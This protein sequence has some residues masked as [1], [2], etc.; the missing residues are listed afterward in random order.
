MKYKTFPK[1]SQTE[2]IRL[3]V[4]LLDQD[5]LSNPNRVWV[6]V[7][8][9]RKEEGIEE[10]WVSFAYVYTCK[11]ISIDHST[12]R[13]LLWNTTWWKFSVGVPLGVLTPA[14]CIFSCIRDTCP[15]A[16][17]VF[18][19]YAKRT[20]PRCRE[21]F[22]RQYKLQRSNISSFILLL[23]QT[24]LSNFSDISSYNVR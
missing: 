6:L 11:Y 7:L 2:K 10:I 23:S 16:I 20:S 5:I 9:Q 15:T 1:S 12:L 13:R 18:Y 21:L 14:I 22:F 4:S 17:F 24:F 19:D 3:I 8:L